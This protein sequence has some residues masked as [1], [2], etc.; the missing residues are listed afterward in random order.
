[1]LDSAATSRAADAAGQLRL[2]RRRTRSASASSLGEGLV[3][4]CALEKQKILLDQRAARLHPHHLRP[5]RG[6]A[7]QHPRAAGHLRGPGQGRA[8][9]G[10]VRAASTRRHQA[11]LDQL[12]ESIGIV[13]NTIEANMR[14][15]DLLKQSQSLAQQLQSRQEE[16][17][18]TNEELQEKARLLAHQNEEVERKNQRGRAG[19]PGAG[20]EGQAARAHLAS[21]SPSSWPT[22]RTSCGR[23]STACSSCPT[24]CRKNPDGNL[25]AASRSSSPRRSTRRATTC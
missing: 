22:C 8:R 14:T 2:R 15:E 3:G 9:A 13:L 24:S 19:P 11:F 1:M 16:L 5:G 18:K 12:T 21:T 25:H 6:A 7:A 23:R 4:Q 17:Q 10:L 20:G